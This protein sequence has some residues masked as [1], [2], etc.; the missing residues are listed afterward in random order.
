M[1]ERTSLPVPDLIATGLSTGVAG[2]RFRS[3]IPVSTSIHSLIRAFD[4][5]LNSSWPPKACVMFTTKPDLL[6]H[7]HASIRHRV[8]VVRMDEA[9]GSMSPEVRGSDRMVEFDEGTLIVDVAETSGK[10]ILWR[11]WSQTDVGGLIDDPR[12][13]EKR[14]NES[15]RLMM[16]QFPRTP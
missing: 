7:Y 14:I 3:A 4:R 11:G 10:S 6:I 12:A 8:D 2:A 16:Q 15:V 9:R 13:M 1:P 5:Q